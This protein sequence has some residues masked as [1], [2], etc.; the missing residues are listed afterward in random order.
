M[1]HALY[2]DPGSASL[3]LQVIGGGV[4]AVSV[5]LKLFW[6]RI[7]IG[8]HLRHED[9]DTPPPAPAPDADTP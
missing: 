6:R 9:D 2:L 3:I 4:V 5:A 1:V 7:L 8:L